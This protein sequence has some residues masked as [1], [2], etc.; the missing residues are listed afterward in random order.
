MIDG[1]LTLSMPL[2]QGG[3]E[4]QASARGISYVANDGLNVVIPDWMAE[5]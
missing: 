2:S 1:K 3:D 4:L 5:R